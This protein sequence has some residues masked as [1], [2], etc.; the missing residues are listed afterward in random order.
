MKLYAEK[1]SMF[2]IHLNLILK[3]AF[4]MGYVKNQVF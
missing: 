1:Q 3:Q 4:L 2:I